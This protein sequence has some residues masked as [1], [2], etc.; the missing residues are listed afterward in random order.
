MR[1]VKIERAW[2]KK[3]RRIEADSQASE[4][5]EEYIIWERN[6]V[7]EIILSYVAKKNLDF[8]KDRLSLKSQLQLKNSIMNW[9]FQIQQWNRLLQSNED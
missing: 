9:R 1:A 5:L 8:V 4:F 2:E 7:L 6:F 3:T